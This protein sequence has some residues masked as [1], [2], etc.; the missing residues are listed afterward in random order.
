VY[1]FFY[2]SFVLDR[3]LI[4][5]PLFLKLTTPLIALQSNRLHATDL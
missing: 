2:L 1:I 5:P 4:V 3:I